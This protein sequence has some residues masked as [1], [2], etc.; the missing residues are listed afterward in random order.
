[1]GRLEELVIKSTKKIFKEV[2]GD[3]VMQAVQDFLRER[4]LNLDDTTLDIEKF[5][6]SLV[7]LFGEGAEALERA[8]V[9]ELYRRLGLVEQRF[10]GFVE[11]IKR[12]EKQL[13]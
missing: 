11:D 2:F 8:I 9:D 1:M 10:S 12:L 5:H 3:V 7:L 13:R 4:D 6:N